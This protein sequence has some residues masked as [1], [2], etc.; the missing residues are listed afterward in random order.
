MKDQTGK[1]N[2]MYK[3]GMFGSKIHKVWDGM[4]QRCHNKN[5]KDYKNWGAKGVVVCKEWREFI[6][7]YNDMGSPPKGKSLD[8]IDVTG[9]YCKKNCRW[10][11]WTEQHQNRR[12]N[13]LLT[14]KNETKPMSY[15]YHK[16]KINRATFTYRISHGWTVDKAIETPIKFV[17]QSQST[18]L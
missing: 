6:N 12:N 5:C 10:A 8:R 11:T 2:H 9:N 7:F 15:W 14:Y 18:T 17:G 16:F 13:R 3:H 4:I 1:K